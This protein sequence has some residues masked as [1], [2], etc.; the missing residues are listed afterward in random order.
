MLLVAAQRRRRGLCSAHVPQFGADIEWDATNFS[1]HDVATIF[2]R[3]LTQ[4]PEPVIPVA[5][6][7]HVSSATRESR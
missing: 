3:F 1:P 2:R 4:M 6:Y 7:N 5:F